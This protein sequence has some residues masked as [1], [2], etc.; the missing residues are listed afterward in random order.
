MLNCRIFL[1]QVSSDPSRLLV[2]LFNVHAW[3]K[4]SNHF[5]I[6]GGEIGQ[7]QATRL[8]LKWYPDL[9]SS[10][11]I[12]RRW[13]NSNYSSAASIKIDGLPDSLRI[14]SEAAHPE[15][16]AKQRYRRAAGAILR[17]RDV[18]P[19]ERMNAESLQ[20]VRLN[21]DKD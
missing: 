17:P 20:K 21:G 1:L 14:P 15:A 7:R 18:L 2:C 12:K 6:V 13:Q 4:A 16:V 8:D 10:G 5:V 19:E 9:R 3:P 11:V